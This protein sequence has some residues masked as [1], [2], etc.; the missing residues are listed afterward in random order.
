MVPRKITEQMKVRWLRQVIGP[1]GNV[2]KE[3]LAER[4]KE[5]GMTTNKNFQEK[6]AIK[7]GIQPK[8]API[9]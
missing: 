5:Q 3:G 7:T 2:P 1:T 4:V 8:M 9:R 6:L